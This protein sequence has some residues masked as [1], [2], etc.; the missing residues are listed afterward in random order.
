MKNTIAYI[1]HKFH[2]KTRSGDF[3]RNIFK[4]KNRVDNFWIGKD[5]QFNKNIFKYRNIFFFQIL[6]PIRILK[7]LKN[8]NI[9]WAPMYDSP[10]YPTGFSNLLWKIVKF[11]NIKVLIFSKKL[12]NK[13]KKN[14]VEYRYFKYFKKQIKIKNKINSNKLKIFFW[15]RN[16]LKVQDWYPYIKS[17]FID[18]ITFLNLSADQIQYVENLNLN[19][20]MI[21]KDFIKHSNFLNLLRKSDIFICPRKKKV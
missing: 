6:P 8:K 20:K 19:K 2:I 13:A 1:D 12:I 16:D 4:K 17:N 11:Y 5:M 21:N 9:V 14:N 18:K 10:H 3:L 7:K 15:Y